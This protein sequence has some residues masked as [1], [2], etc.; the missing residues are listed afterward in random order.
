MLVLT[1]PFVAS[2]LTVSFFERFVHAVLLLFTRRGRSDAKG[3]IS[4]FLSLFTSAIFGLL[5]LIGRFLSSAGGF[6]FWFM[7]MFVLLSFV[8]VSYEQYPIVWVRGVEI[9]NDRVG[10]FM[11]TYVL[12]PLQVGNLFLKAVIPLWNSVI[13]FFKMLWLQG[14]LPSFFSE[15]EIARSM[16]VALLLLGRDCSASLSNYVQAAS[17]KTDLCLTQVPELDVVGPMKNVATLAILAGKM[18]GDVCGPIATMTEVALFQLVDPKLAQAAHQLLNAALAAVIYIPIATDKRCAE[19]GKTGTAFDTLMCT[20]DLEVVKVYIVEGVRALGQVLDNWIGVAFNAVNARLSGVPS[21]CDPGA[22]GVTPDT[23]RNGVLGGNMT[24]IGLTDWLLATT[25]GTH[26][27]F[28][29]PG[30]SSSTV[31]LQR[32]PDPGVDVSMGV[33]AVKYGAVNQAHVSSLTQ[34]RQPG[35]A[36][37][38]TLLGCR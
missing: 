18:A 38:T 32:W 27:A 13:Y 29:T 9:Y 1:L 4:Q 7:V 5:G 24:T 20:P 2:L 35:A 17:C 19:Y 10:P 8:Y 25:N 15:L 31:T 33:A 37:T 26:A 21:T 3:V 30:S 16:G 36:Q 22:T 14:L 34:G 28:F 6:L 12:L 23:F 11:Q